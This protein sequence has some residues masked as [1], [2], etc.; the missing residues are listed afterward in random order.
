VIQEYEDRLNELLA[1]VGLSTL[2]TSQSKQFNDYLSLIIR[3]N[4]RTNLTST[5]DPET[6]LSR[7]FVESIAC[8]Q[9]LP[10]GIATLL[11]YGSGAGFPGIPIS[12]CRPDLAITLAESQGK[13]AAFLQ[14]AVRVTGIT[15]KIHSGRAET[16]AT[17]F[18]CVTLRAV[19]HMDRAVQAATHL[20][21]PNGWLALLT[22]QADLPNLQTAAGPAFLWSEP[23]P[24]PGSDNRIL[25]LA[26]KS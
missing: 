15:A 10:A 5:R 4:A 16:L 21:S 23:V 24:L 11:D 19:D 3:W 1:D 12:I 25:A 9:A 8:A 14:E 2:Q 17:Q 18:D 26:L 7:H 6:I 22:T 20:I 13:K